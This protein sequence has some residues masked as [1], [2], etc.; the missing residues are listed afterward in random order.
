MTVQAVLKGAG[1]EGAAAPSAAAAS[2]TNSPP[3]FTEGEKTTRDIAE[4]SAAGANVGAPVTAT[5]PDDDQLT[6][7]LSDNA[8]FAINSDTGQI[9]VAD[10]VTLDYESTPSHIVPLHV[11][12]GKGGGDRIEVTVV[13]T[14]DVV[15]AKPAAPTVAPAADADPRRNVDV[16]WTAPD[17][18]GAPITDYDVQYRQQGATEWLDHPF[19]GAGLTTTIGGLEFAT[20]YEV[21]VLARS[22]EGDSPWSDAGEVTTQAN[23]PPR[24]TSNQILGVNLSVGHLAQGPAPLNH[25][26]ETRTAT[27][28]TLR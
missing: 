9:T 15:P 7:A 4:N 20:T 17:G 16:Q 26:S 10:G 19:D 1:A 13:V 8:A 24:T 11:S 22:A 18:A 27:R 23:Q 14:N 2:S 28:C 21:R 5:D 25:F 3:S 6:Y 12:D